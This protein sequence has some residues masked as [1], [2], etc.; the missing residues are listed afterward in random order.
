MLVAQ[1][2]KDRAYCAA[3]RAKLRRAKLATED[4]SA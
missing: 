4:S 3:A 2:K 1:L